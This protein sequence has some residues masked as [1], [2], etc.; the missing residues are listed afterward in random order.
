MKPINIAIVDDHNLFRNGLSGKGC[1]ELAE[2]IIK[3]DYSVL[4]EDELRHNAPFAICTLC[5]GETRVTKEYHRGLL[6][7]IDGFQYYNGE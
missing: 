2:F 6:R 1:V 7:Q 5:V 3:S 4:E